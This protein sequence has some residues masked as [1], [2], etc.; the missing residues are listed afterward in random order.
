MRR[1]CWLKQ[2]VPDC[3]YTPTALTGGEGRGGRREGGGEERRRGKER[4]RGRVSACT[5]FMYRL[6]A[7]IVCV[8]CCMR[9]RDSLGKCSPAISE[10][11][12]V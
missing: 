12:T 5:V 11:S 6:C 1:D 10:T 7:A 3:K 8:S 2:R 9:R 4:E